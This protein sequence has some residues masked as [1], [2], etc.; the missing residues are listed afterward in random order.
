[1][2]AG[3]MALLYAWLLFGGV[4][5]RDSILLQLL[6]FALFLG[7]IYLL[8]ASQKFYTRLGYAFLVLTIPPLLWDA[9]IFRLR[10]GDPGHCLDR[11]HG[12]I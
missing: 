6:Y 3:L 9:V 5:S 1:M 4:I 7:V 8:R 10:S 2:I 11:I 12:P